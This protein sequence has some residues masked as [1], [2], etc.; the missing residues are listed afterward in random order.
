MKT[1]DTQLNPVSPPVLGFCS[2]GERFIA[3]LGVVAS[4]LFCSTVSVRAAAASP[5]ITNL[6][7]V[8]NPSLD[9]TDILNR[10]TINAVDTSFGLFLFQTINNLN[11]TNALGA[12]MIGD[13]GFDLQYV[14]SDT[15]LRAPASAI[16][17]QGL[18][19]ADT[20]L[21]SATNLVNSGQLRAGAAGVLQLQG[22]NVNVS[23]SVLS[24]SDTSTFSSIGRGFRSVDTN[25][26]VTYQ[27]ATAITDLYWGAGTNNVMRTRGFGMFLPGLNFSLFP[28]QV[29]S[30]SYEVES[31]VGGF[32]SFT[33]FE[34]IFG[35]NFA[36]FVRTTRQG[37]NVN[38]QVVLVQTNTAN[39]NLSVDV[40]FASI[41]GGGG[42]GGNFFSG[43]TPILRFSTFGS[44]I[45]TGTLYTN[46]L[47]FLDYIN[48]LTNAVL[49][50]N[51]VASSSR[52]AAYELTRT[53]FYEQYFSSSFFGFTTNAVL[54]NNFFHEFG[55]DQDTVT[56]NFYAAYQVAVGNAAI[57]PG[58]AAYVPHLD[59]PTNSPGRIDISANNL[60]L[61]GARIQAENFVS[62]RTDNLISSVATQIEAPY[63]QL[64]IANTNLTLTLTNFAP[65]QVAR[66]NGT[67]SFY[68]TI[69]TN[70]LTNASP[71]L[72]YRYHVLIVDASQLSGVTPVTLQEFSARGTNV[73]INNPLNIGRSVRVTSPAVTFSAS[74]TLILPLLAATNLTVANFPTVQ[75]FTNLGTIN[76]P[77]QCLLGSDR[78]TPITSFLNRGNI[79]ANSIEISAVDYENSGTNQTR[80]LVNATNGGGGGPVS[81]RAGSA[82]LDGGI[83]GG[84]ISAGGSILLAANDLKLR[85]HR[86]STAGT[87]FLSPTNSLTDVGA[88]GTNRIDVALGFALTIKPASG[89]LLGTTIYTTAPFIGDVPH[90][91]AGTD[92]GAVAAGYTNNAALGRLLLD[93]SNNPAAINRL[94]FSGTGTNNALYVDYLDL[95]GTLTNDLASH[96][97]IGTNMT[98]YFANSN[99][100]PETLDRQLGGRLRWVKDYAGLNTGVDVQLRDGRTVK[101]NVAKL[102]SQ[103]LDS[104]ADGV[105]NASDLNPFDGI[106]INSRVTFANV[107]P[108][109]A[110]VTWEAAAQTVYQVEVNT[111]LLVGTWQLL[112]NFTNS[113]TTNRVVS[114]YDVVPSSGTQRYF[115][116][117][118]QP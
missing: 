28:P 13:V 15:G 115:R 46:K 35:T 76:V 2:H 48:G 30:P 91:W 5:G 65:S 105:V 34:Q 69:W 38:V 80:L 47:Y 83:T 82:K 16:V 111:N 112:A 84:M 29:F 57:G 102:N 106:V 93:T 54:T 117:S 87:L 90:F 58:T 10:G 56:N 77:I 101:V 104:D 32:G 6:S 70:N 42:F 33:S 99:L 72:S 62:I 100:L 41:S 19:V 52:P 3:V 26:V 64:D 1:H 22:Q 36:P 18:I 39:T 95:A 60:D 75:Y 27:N 71:T 50:D 86:L 78:P 118:Y 9:A 107:P 11:F 7:T 59:D 25:G 43:I 94:I 73:I 66:L 74:S 37:T 98:I 89:D 20:I 44:D 4:L 45:T 14:T 88:S 24:A 97:V 79:T 55:F 63:I 40:R 51:T 114:F 53:S 81:I 116:I 109:T 103:T 85:N 17:N 96:L 21:L 110:S 23:R 31:V 8:T 68:S 61:S 92:Y 113:A 49:S 67:L 108:L 12:R